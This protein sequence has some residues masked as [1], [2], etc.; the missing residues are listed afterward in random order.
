[1]KKIIIITIIFYILI[2]SCNS[3]NY[4]NVCYKDTNYVNFE[5][6]E[7][8]ETGVDTFYYIK[9]PYVINKNWKVFY[10][11]EFK[12]LVLESTFVNDTCLFKQYYSNGNLKHL[13]TIDK[14]G[15]ILKEAAWYSNNQL[16]YDTDFSTLYSLVIEYYPNGK[17]MKEFTIARVFY[18]G[19][20][21][22]WYE[23]GNPKIFGQYQNNGK[24]GIWKYYNKNGD[25][26]KTEEYNNDKLIKEE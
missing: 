12:N 19:D 2:S 5:L 8:F 9:Y 6:V 17:K 4:S 1:M 18:I 20:Y 21:K 10:D 22:E 23:D 26:E 14:D 16:I 13:K 7:N 3:Q 11:K 25:L 24:D 15:H